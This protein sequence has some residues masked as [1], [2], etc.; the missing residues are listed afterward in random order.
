MLFF[1]D[2]LKVISRSENVLLYSGQV[3]VN[4]TSISLGITLS[5]AAS[6]SR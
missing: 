4:G 2:M 1:L 3:K 5:S 6:L